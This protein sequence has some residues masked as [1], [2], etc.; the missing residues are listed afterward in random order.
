MLLL[1]LANFLLFIGII[2]TLTFFISLFKKT[3]SNHNFELACIALMLL[4][5]A[6]ML[7]EKVLGIDLL[8]Y[9]QTILF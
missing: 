5:S 9:I 2:A 1:M 8:T 4:G 6:A 3:V 7:F